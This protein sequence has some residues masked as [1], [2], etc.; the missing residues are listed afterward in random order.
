MGSSP[1][2]RHDLQV[3]AQIRDDDADVSSIRDAIDRRKHERLALQSRSDHHVNRVVQERR[4]GHPEKAVRREAVVKHQLDRVLAVDLIEVREAVCTGDR[5]CPFAGC[6]TTIGEKRS[7]RA[8]H[9]FVG[10]G[11]FVEFVRDETDG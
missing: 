11:L 5:E 2:V 6:G 8:L 10:P 3:V 9:P 1:G 4:V 7:E